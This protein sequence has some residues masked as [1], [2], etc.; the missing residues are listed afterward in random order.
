MWG[1]DRRPGVRDGASLHKWEGEAGEG[2]CRPA[3]LGENQG[4]GA[5]P[6]LKELGKGSCKAAGA[7]WVLA[8][9]E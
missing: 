4:S 1:D 3:H 7:G 6:C 8:Q 2:K 9:R 5:A